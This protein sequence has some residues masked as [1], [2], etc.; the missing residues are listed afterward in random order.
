MG[1]YYNRVR[2]YDVERFNAFDDW[3]GR[4]GEN[5]TLN[6]YLYGDRAAM[7]SGEVL[8]ISSLQ[9]KLTNGSNILVDLV[10]I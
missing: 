7:L 9:T 4:A 8:S 5:V 6:K 2:Y 1:M 3:E 10:S